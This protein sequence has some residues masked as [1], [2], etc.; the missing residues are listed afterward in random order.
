MDPKG[1]P[2]L[3]LEYNCNIL[4]WNVRGLNNPVRRKVVRDLVS[5]TKATIVALQETKLE[6]VDA[7]LV[8]EILGTCFVQNFVVLPAIGT[9]GGIL[10][11]T[12]E[13]H[14]KIVSAEVG[15]HTVTATVQ[16]ISGGRCGASLLSMAHK[17]IKRSCNS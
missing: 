5:E 12:N 6:Q 4:N 16:A 10:L 2:L 9:R 1:F 14:Y 3:M 17:M 8:S 11:G 13:E 15:V 7:A